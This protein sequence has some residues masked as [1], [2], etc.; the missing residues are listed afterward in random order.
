MEPLRKS[1]Q[2]V[3]NIVRFNWHYYIILSVMLLVLIFIVNSILEMPETY[4]VV[5]VVL[6]V[7][8]VFIS[9]LV[10][11]YIYDCSDLYKLNWLNSIDHKDS[12]ALHIINIHAGFDE[13]SVLLKSRFPDSRLLVF[14][15]YDP[16][17]HT[18]VSIRRAR[19]AYE[20]F[21]GTQQVITTDFP[22]DTGAA[23]L[24]CNLLSAHEIRDFQERVLFFKELVRGV[25]PDGKI[26]VTEH[27]RDLANFL[28]YTI[29]FLHFHSRASWYRTFE[30]AGLKVIREIKITPFIST[31]ILEKYDTTS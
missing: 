27:L 1:F 23:D 20:S 29:G 11:F 9:L 24:I 4:S 31:F 15:Y 25:K 13:T 5:L 19:K 3:T 17:K 18:E 30:L 12:S 2:G 16:V 8:P 7:L 6:F 10:S 21:P 22:F 28:A 26:I 14:D